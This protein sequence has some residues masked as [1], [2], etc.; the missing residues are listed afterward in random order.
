M[1]QV[2]TVGGGT[3]SYTLLSGIK[4]IKNT[5]ISA[6]V[7]MT[8]DGGSAGVLRD[9]LGVLPP[10][11]VRQCLMALSEHTEIV[12]ELMSY[13]FTEG[14]LSGHSLGNL[15]LAGLE[16]VT[17]SFI[18][19][20]EVAS[21]I[22]KVKGRVLPVIDRVASLEATLVDGKKIIGEDVINQMTHE[23]NIIRSVSITK[24][25]HIN[26]HAKNAIESAD[27]IIIGPGNHFCSILP[28]LVVPG[29]HE[30]CRQSK[31]KIVYITNLTNKKGHTIGWKVSDYVK[32]IELSLSRRVDMVL[33]NN[34]R[35][36]DEQLTTYKLTEGDGVLV[37]NDMGED[38]RV[39][40]A[41]IMAESL[42]KESKGDAIAHTRSFIRHDSKKLG[43]VIA[44][45]IS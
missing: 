7:A 40:L 32:S 30:A 9:E 44:K 6:I 5:S 39:V 14:G 22:L 3:S 19:G 43:E 16:K 35:P 23:T 26:P 28:N 37:E 15:L 33:I 11:D 20:V 12:R 13:R 24:D 4:N 21:E 17:G 27:Y 36:S 1:I 25:A 31:A 45:I 41:S 29:V 34:A 42:T 2:V 38:P 8:D 18:E 10:G